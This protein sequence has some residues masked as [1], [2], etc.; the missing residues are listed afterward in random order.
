MSTAREISRLKLLSNATD[1]EMNGFI[2]AVDRIGK[3]SYLLK[4]DIIG[5]LLEL[6][7]EG[8]KNDSLI[9]ELEKEIKR[10]RLSEYSRYVDK[11]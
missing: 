7:A 5:K 10:S 2:E 4:I 8:I 3:E 11:I 6:S 1:A 9:L